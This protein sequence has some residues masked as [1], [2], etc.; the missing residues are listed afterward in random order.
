ME[1][2]HHLPR[3]LLSQVG[4]R[5]QEAESQPWPGPAY[6][7]FGRVHG[8]GAGLIQALGDHHITEGTVEPSHL[9]NVKALVCP[10]DVA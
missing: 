4:G 1:H 8:D 2:L 7:P 10:V 5:E 3:P 6:P 9:N